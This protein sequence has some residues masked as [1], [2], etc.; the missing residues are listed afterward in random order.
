MTTRLL[1]VRDG[2]ESPWRRSR[3]GHEA[4]VDRAARHLDAAGRAGTGQADDRRPAALREPGPDRQRLVIVPRRPVQPD[5]T[6]VDVGPQRSTDFQLGS[7]LAISKSFHS[8]FSR[9][10]SSRVLVCQREGALETV[11]EDPL[12]GRPA[13]CRDAIRVTCFEILV[14]GP[15]NASL[16]CDSASFHPLSI[17]TKGLPC[18]LAQMGIAPYG[19]AV[20][21]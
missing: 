18:H 9:V 20:D 16:D 21:T 10:T 17:T 2:P 4:H 7:C 8:A 15:R 14:D 19:A 13:A 1:R 6:G 11:M 5:A 12:T 3:R